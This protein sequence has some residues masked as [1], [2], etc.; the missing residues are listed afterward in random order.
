MD[1]LIKKYAEILRTAKIGDYTYEGILAEFARAVLAESDSKAVESPAI[2]YEPIINDR[3]PGT[4]TGHG[5]VWRRPDGQRQHC[6]YGQ[7]SCQQCADDNREFGI[8]WPD[9]S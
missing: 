5:H 8:A 9:R 7:G 2:P 6:G 3:G 1:A 4:N